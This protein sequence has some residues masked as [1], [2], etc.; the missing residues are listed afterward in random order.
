[1]YLLEL[2]WHPHQSPEESNLL[3]PEVHPLGVSLPFFPICLNNLAEEA[4]AGFEEHLENFFDLKELKGK[5][6]LEIYLSSLKR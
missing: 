3:Q 4:V 6:C 2:M 1:M 5:A